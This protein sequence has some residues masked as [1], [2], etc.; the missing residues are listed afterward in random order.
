M[1]LNRTIEVLQQ[2]LNHHCRNG[3]KPEQ[4]VVNTALM[5]A[6]DG[7]SLLRDFPARLKRRDRYDDNGFY[8][9]TEVVSVIKGR[10]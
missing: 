10:V 9:G 5:E 4:Y 2:E 7:L 1:D 3:E 8:D 6:I